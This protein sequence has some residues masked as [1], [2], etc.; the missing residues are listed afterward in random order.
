V[1]AREWK[2]G[3]VAMVPFLGE[4]RICVYTD[5]GWVGG[6][7]SEKAGVD[8]YAGARHLVVI[9]PEDYAQVERLADLLSVK[10]VH[11]GR[12]SAVHECV[13]LA[14]ALRE[15]PTGGAR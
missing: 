4:S 7:L 11:V 6:K 1:S 13:A 3:D 8:H 12:T 2:P 14:D 15:F 5:G 9:D 10:G